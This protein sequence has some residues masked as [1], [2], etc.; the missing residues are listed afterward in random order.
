MGKIPNHPI[1]GKLLGMLMVLAGMLGASVAP[2]RADHVFTLELAVETALEDNPGLAART[3]AALAMAE[4]PAQAGALPNPT[5]TLGVLNVPPDSLSFTDEPMTQFQVGVRQGLPFPG[6]R[7][8]ARREAGHHAE[9]ALRD[10]EEARLTLTAEV[11][12]A[13]WRLFQTVRALEIVRRNQELLRQFVQVARTKYKVGKGLQQDVLLAE[14]ELSKLIDTELGLEGERGQ[15]QARLN[16]LMGRPGGIRID[17]PEQVD[18]SLVQPPP[19][20]RLLAQADS[21]RPALVAARHRFEA[22]SERLVLAHKASR[23]DF[24]VTGSYSL[25]GGSGAGGAARSDLASVMVGIDLPVRPNSRQHRQVAQREHER[26]AAAL[27]LE[28]LQ[29]TI[30]ADVS[31]LVTEYDAARRRTELF[32][33][34]IIPQASQM[35]ASMMAGYQVNKVD[36]LNLVRSQVTLYDY[37]VRYWNALTTARIAWARL[38]AAVGGG[39]ESG[40]ERPARGA[41]FGEKTPV[42][43][44]A[45]KGH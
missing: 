29:L 26:N 37:Q 17:L 6:K 1:A 13:W 35:V 14:V 15:A 44:G 4:V 11:Q 19:P 7:A 3:E 18:T 10:A 24:S 30:Q 40:P 38:E 43:G 21:R 20:V 42:D 2:A 34:G 28:Q 23:P 27:D 31:R 5:L 45:H 12:T 16:A 25:R 36:F 8:L 32:Q 22:A 33:A 41:G 39:L 9:A